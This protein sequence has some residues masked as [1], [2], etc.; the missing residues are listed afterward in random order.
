MNF[1]MRREERQDVG[2]PAWLDPGDGGALVRCTLI[3]ISESG[4]K[5]AIEEGE[6][7]PESFNLCLSRWRHPRYA[8]RVVWR[9]AL[10][11]G[12]TFGPRQ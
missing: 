3:D 7:V 4:A 8:C 1:Q 9:N 11:I 2:R 12:V 5:I 10:A 6:Q